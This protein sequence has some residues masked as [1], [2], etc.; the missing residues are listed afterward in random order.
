MNLIQL[1]LQK[2]IDIPKTNNY[3]FFQVIIPRFSGEKVIKVKNKSKE[4]NTIIYGND[5]VDYFNVDID[6]QN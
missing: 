3:G 4:Y 1:Q 5:S 2:E 6:L